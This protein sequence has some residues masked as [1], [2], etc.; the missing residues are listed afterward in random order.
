MS[1]T[2]GASVSDLGVSAEIPDVAAV[3]FLGGSMT[4]RLLEPWEKDLYLGR[5]QSPNHEYWEEILT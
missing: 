4:A 2:G 5:H 3:D 1:I